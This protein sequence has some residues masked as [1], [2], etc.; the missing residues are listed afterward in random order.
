MDVSRYERAYPHLFDGLSAA[1]RRLV[2]LSISTTPSGSLV[3][4]DD[5]RDLVE[6]V[7]GR[8]SFEEYMQRAR[9][10]RAG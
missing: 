4:E 10:S 8:I 2:V 3:A 7:T 6:R 9:R 1:T 5:V